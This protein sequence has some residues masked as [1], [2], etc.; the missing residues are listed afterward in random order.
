MNLL[1]SLVLK[2]RVLASN[3]E[4]SK[5]TKTLE[6]K[7]ISIV[8][9]F[10]KTCED[11]HNSYMNRGSGGSNDWY[12]KRNVFDAKISE[13]SN[14]FQ[15]VFESFIP[16]KDRSSFFLGRYDTS[17]TQAMLDSWKSE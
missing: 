6:N 9:R 13:L 17:D 5:W 14:Q 2:S 4:E 3:C 1:Y 16:K 15:L 10:N 8:G 7:F 11:E 12:E